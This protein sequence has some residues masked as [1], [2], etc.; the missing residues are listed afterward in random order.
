MADPLIDEIRQ[1]RHQISA[2]HGH[3]IDR[4][5]Q[6][7]R[8]LHQELIHSGKFREASPHAPIAAGTVES[9]EPE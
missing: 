1:I 7:L 2:E 8:E 9:N 3:D 4:Y 6:H 5:L